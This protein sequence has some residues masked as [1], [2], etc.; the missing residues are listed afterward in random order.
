MSF[1]VGDR[2][3]PS[4]AAVF[5]D[6]HKAAHDYS[7]RTPDMTGTVITVGHGQNEGRY[8]VAWDTPGHAFDH[9]TTY[10]AES[11]LEPL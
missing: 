6:R 1:N 4:K 9:W 10:Q 5:R 2:V 3:R 7:K 8:N 11:L